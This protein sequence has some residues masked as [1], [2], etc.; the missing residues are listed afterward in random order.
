MEKPFRAVRN[1]MKRTVRK[2]S[3]IKP[4]MFLIANPHTPEAD[5]LSDL[6]IYIPYK[7]AYYGKDYIDCNKKTGIMVLQ[8]TNISTWSN[9]NL[10]EQDKYFGSLKAKD[11][12]DY[13]YLHPSCER[14]KPEPKRKQ[15]IF[16]LTIENTSQMFSVYRCNNGKL[17]VGKYRSFRNIADNFCMLVDEKTNSNVRL[18]HQIDVLDKFS[19]I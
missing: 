7:Y 4:V 2:F 14:I 10:I 12:F 1:L 11:D 3:E 18:I 13:T 19:E 9:E 8:F 5:I 17:W 16:N 15:L 6:N